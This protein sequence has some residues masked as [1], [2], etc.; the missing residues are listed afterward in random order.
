MQIVIYGAVAIETITPPVLL[1]L[2]LLWVGFEKNMH[3]R[4]TPFWL[5]MEHVFG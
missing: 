5:G 3:S 2:C 1:N 4:A